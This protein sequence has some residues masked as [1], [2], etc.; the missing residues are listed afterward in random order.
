MIAAMMPGG[1]E[2][3]GN[4]RELT[5]HVLSDSVGETA[6]T[7]G[8]IIAIQF[9]QFH[10]NY[11]LT[12]MIDSVQMLHDTVMAHRGD[13]SHLFIYTFTN[14]ALREEMI[15]MRYPDCEENR[16]YSIDVLGSGLDMVAD[17]TGESPSG[18]VGMLHK[19]DSVYFNRIE[20]MEFAVN[21]DDGQLPDGLAEADVVL[22]GV[23]RTSKTPL[24]MYLAHRGL[25]TA[26][27]PLTLE[28]EPPEQLFEL[29]SS[30]VFGLM[31]GM[32]T[33]LK[34]R[35]ERMAE[36]GAYVPNYAEPEY[37]AAEFEYARS[38]MRKL[39]ALIINTENRAIES[40]AQEILSHLRPTLRNTLNR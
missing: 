31:T 37:V 11:V 20:A 35:Q 34:V 2:K 23:S 25:K 29:E 6:D 3:S 13:S 22:I 14:P 10:W 15:T 36:F 18:M 27:I 30:K 24:S 8:H 32:D 16:I 9:P 26:N 1:G 12:T 7:V 17:L 33:L 40:V 5:L 4:K 19:V 21:H 39:G 28:T 38:L